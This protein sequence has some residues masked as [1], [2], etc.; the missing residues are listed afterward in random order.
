MQS[1]GTNLISLADWHRKQITV[2]LTNSNPAKYRAHIDGLRAIAVLPVLFYHAEIGFHG[3]YVG[4]DVFFVISG[5][6]ITGLILNDLEGGRFSI[7][8]FWERRMRRILPAL[9]VVVAS[10]VALGWFILSPRDF[11]TLG[12]SVTA[13]ALLVSNIFFC[14]TSRWEGGYFD[15]AAEVK[16]LL[17]TWSLALEEQFYL[18]FPFL[19][20]LFK[21]VSRKM[22]ITALFVLCCY[23]FILC[24]YCSHLGTYLRGPI[25]FYLLP[26]RAWELLIGSCLAAIPARPASSRW[27]KESLGW[28]GLLAILVAVFFYDRDTRFPGVAALLPSI[29]AALL[30]WANSQALTSSGKLLAARP[31]VFIGLISYSLYLWHW[32]VLL[33]SKYWALDPIPPTQRMLLLLASFVLAWLSWRFVETPFRKRLVLTSRGPDVFTCEPCHLRPGARGS[34]HKT[35]QWSA[36]TDSRQ[37]AGVPQY[38]HPAGVRAPVGLEGRIGRRLH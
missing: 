21:G 32:P 16:P 28:I 38:G 17:H 11:K 3:G 5:Y 36:F 27:L 20:M 35:I 31:L 7:L 4:V 12:E 6:L 24:V 29:G 23:S 25:N 18:L 8:D 30:I 37:D 33:F 15:Q 9:L 26:M 10:C 34:N 22:L 13:Q 19:L 2:S 14:M 1:Q